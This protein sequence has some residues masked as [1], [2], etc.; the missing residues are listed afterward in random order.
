MLHSYKN[1]H[2][3]CDKETPKFDN[4]YRICG[5][6]IEHIPHTISSCPK[7]SSLC[8]LLMR[9]DGEVKALYNE[10]RAKD[11]PEIKEF[12]LTER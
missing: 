10:M 3:Q 9:H 7:I 11:K 5:V 6:T 2:T 1:K 12:K 4:R 8:H